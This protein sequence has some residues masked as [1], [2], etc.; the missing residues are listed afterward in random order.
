MNSLPISNDSTYSKSKF[1]NKELRKVSRF[2]HQSMLLKAKVLLVQRIALEKE[3][4]HKRSEIFK[5]KIASDDNVNQLRS[6]IISGEC[7][8]NFLNNKEKGIP[9]YW[10]KAMEGSSLYE[11]FITKRDREALVHLEN[12]TSMP[13]SNGF[14]IQF[15]F[16]PNSFFTDSVLIKQYE[17]V[18]TEDGINNIY[19]I[20]SSKINW[21]SDNVNLTKKFNKRGEAELEAL[22]FFT[23]FRDYIR[24]EEDESSLTAES[25]ILLTDPNDCINDECMMG[26]FIID[27]F[28]PNS[29]KFYMN[30]I[31]RESKLKNKKGKKGVKTKLE[32]SDDSWIEL[33]DDSLDNGI[34]TTRENIQ[35]TIK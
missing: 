13:K 12:I 26:S 6:Q 29:A 30:S 8:I 21:I 25:D 33:E 23:N 19:K 28:I 32:D 18:I 5:S 20:S 31:I 22:S 16:A 14:E 1:F 2:I 35:E 34:L 9:N 7:D 3:Y 10:L 24:K 4:F 17:S 15:H 27:E 11:F